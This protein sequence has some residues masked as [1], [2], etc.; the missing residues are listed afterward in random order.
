ML[1]LIAFL[2]T[3]ALITGAILF[4]SPTDDNRKRM[5]KR[6]ERLRATRPES[7]TSIS[8]PLLKRVKAQSR[9]WLGYSLRRVTIAAG[10]DLLIEQANSRW[11]A[12][13]I[14]L[15][16]GFTS[17]LIG[18][19]V[20]L[21]SPLPMLAPVVALP[22]SYIPFAV[23]RFLRKRRVEAFEKTLPDL[24]ETMSRS[25]RAGHS[26]VS[27]ISVV[28]ESAPEPTRSEFAQVFRKQNF[29]LPLR[30]ALM[31]MLGRV[32][33]YDLRVLVTG[34]LL[35]KDTGGDLTQIF[36]RTSEVIRGRL[37]LR[38]D[39]R[40]HTAQGRMTGW[41][42]SLLPV[43]LVL[44][45][46]IVDPGY[47]RALTDDPFGRKLLYASIGLLLAGIFLIHR[48]VTGVEA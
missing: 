44:L 43:V 30:D 35:Q 22:V 10:L 12:K 48:I 25:L 20:F 13:G 42:L 11:T 34:I 37:K 15:V 21:L 45:I 19:A 9:G 46:N 7:D 32:P 3:V 40:V 33:S 38:G 41:I 27:A 47:S 2:T 18:L 24:I 1:L 14:L 26:L 23:L 4:A 17:V 16:T 8:I 29:G 28:A 31:Q 5:T 6:F 36:D 39:I